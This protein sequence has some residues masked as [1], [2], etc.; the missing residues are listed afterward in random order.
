MPNL[1]G[2]KERAPTHTDKYPR[3]I[4]DSHS[5]AALFEIIMRGCLTV[6]PS[7][8]AL[9]AALPLFFPTVLRVYAPF[10]WLRG[11]GVCSG[12]PHPGV[13]CWLRLRPGPGGPLSAPVPPGVRGSSSAAGTDSVCMA[14]LDPEEHV[15]PTVGAGA[16]THRHIVWRYRSTPARATAN[17]L[18][19]APLAGG[20][21]VG[22]CQGSCSVQG[23]GSVVGGRLLFTVGDGQSAVQGVTEV[24]AVQLSQ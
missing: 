8:V 10:V 11:L 12:R 16:P 22:A 9:C 17:P 5:H 6:T 13:G 15:V 1:C 20:K 18:A 24:W 23:C 2:T 21:V 4:Q 14:G 3:Q 7:F 19:V